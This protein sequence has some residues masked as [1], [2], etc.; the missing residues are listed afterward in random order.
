MRRYCGPESNR[1]DEDTDARGGGPQEEGAK[2]AT[3]RPG[4]GEGSGLAP[5]GPQVPHLQPRENK[6]LLFQPLSLRFFV[7]VVLENNYRP[8]ILKTPA[9]CHHS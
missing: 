7:M 8:Q 6:V 3:H 1:R 2:A 5:P 9:N 4:G